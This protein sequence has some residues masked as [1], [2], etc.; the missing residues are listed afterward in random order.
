VRRLSAAAGLKVGTTS[1]P[2]TMDVTY[3]AQLQ[4]RSI[5]MQLGHAIA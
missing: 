3:G 4:A 1:A 2:L 5:V